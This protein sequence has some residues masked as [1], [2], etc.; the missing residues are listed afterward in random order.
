MTG[1]GGHAARYIVDYKRNHLL[2]DKNVGAA[3]RREKLTF[4]NEIG[5][6]AAATA[7]EVAAEVVHVGSGGGKKM[8]RA[9]EFNLK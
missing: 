3:R 7:A 1:G 8:G 6:T 2:G 5:A 4:R 9:S